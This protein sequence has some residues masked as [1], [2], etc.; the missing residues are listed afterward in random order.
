MTN[1]E[2]SNA[3]DEILRTLQENRAEL[4][5]REGYSEDDT[6]RLLITP[7]LEYLGHLAAHRRSEHEVNRNRPDEIIYDRPASRA[8]NL[9]CRIVLEAKPLGTEFDQGHSR[10]ETPAR[11]VKRYLRDHPASGPDTY[12]VLT[13]GNKYRISRRTGYG[14]DIR[15]IGEWRILDGSTLDGE[16]PIAEVVCLIHLDAVNA[17]LEPEQVAEQNQTRAA[18]TLANAIAVGYSP[19]QILATL[20]PN[21]EQKPAIGT[22]LTLTGRAFDAMR[23]DWENHA[24]RH[25]VGIKSDNPDFQGNRAVVAVLKYCAPSAG[26]PPEL[27]RGDVAL[28][29]RTFARASTCRTA[30]LVAYQANRDG[31]VDRARLAVHY[32]GHTGMT[33]EFDP[34]NPPASVLKSL[35]QIRVALRSASTIAPE[36][37]TNAVNARVIRKEFYESIAAWT[38]AKQHGTTAA[39]RQTLLRHLIR[40]VFAWILKEDDIIPAEPFEEQFASHYGG[41]DYH[42]KILTFLFHSRL[43][44]PESQRVAHR[45]LQVEETLAATPFLNGSLFAESPGDDDLKLSNDDYFGTDPDSPG[46]FTI[47]A[48]YNWTTAEHTPDESDQTIDPEMLSNLFENLVSATE[49]WINH[50]DR[51][52]R[53]TYYTPAD[54]AT[55]M[56]KDALSAAVRHRAPARLT[57]SASA[58]FVWQP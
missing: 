37:L 9:S 25:G 1:A 56:V 43:N 17:A 46:L 29:A 55:E 12:G 54:V 26:E 21:T 52:P 23:S 48:R 39:Q 40:T 14:E 33:S 28:A 51:M 58:G 5:G 27:R 22:E 3:Q 47:M 35:E 45:T 8:G 11:Q 57:G 42:K 19:S 20:T 44:T 38:N 13:D 24:W 31:V 6:I 53:G 4:Q 10:T 7:F 15:H 34:H 36:K 41:D 49:V 50:P 18:R 2:S 32:Q 30:V 16:D